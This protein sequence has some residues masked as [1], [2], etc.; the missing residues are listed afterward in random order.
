MDKL[1]QIHNGSIYTQAI[2]RL[3]QVIGGPLLLQLEQ[4]LLR[5]KN[6]LE[7]LMKEKDELEID[8]TCS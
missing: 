6:I 5:N 1:S 2:T 7:L 8:L 3:L 4:Q